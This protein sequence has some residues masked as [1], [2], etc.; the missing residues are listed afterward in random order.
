MRGGNIATIAHIAH[1][2]CPGYA[3]LQTEPVCTGIV[4]GQ[5]LAKRF[6]LIER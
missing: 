6:V 4:I 1:I 2:V 3:I 5:I